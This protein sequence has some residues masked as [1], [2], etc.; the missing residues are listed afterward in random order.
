[1]INIGVFFGGTSVE[2][3]VS[4]ITAQ[5]AISQLLDMKHYK[6]VPIYISKDNNWYTGD[7]LLEIEHF[8][9]LKKVIASSHRCHMVKADKCAHLIHAEMKLFKKTY[10]CDIDLAFPIIHGTGGEDGNLQ[11]FLEHM[12]IPYVG[13]NVLAASLTMDK[14][15]SKLFLQNSGIRVVEG[16]WFYSHHWNQYASS[17]IEDLEKK[18][19]YPLIVKPADIGSSVGVKP[20]KTRSA[21]IEAIDFAKQFS[22]RILIE[23]MLDDMRE[24]NIAVLGDSEK[25]KL[26]VCEEPL[27][28][29]DFLTYE[30]KYVNEAGSKGMSSAKRQIPAKLSD[31]LKNEIECMAAEAFIA[32]D[33]AGVSRIDFMIDRKT[34]LPYINEFNTIPGSLSFYLWEATGVTFKQ[35]LEEMIEAAYRSHRRKSSLIRSNSINILSKADLSGIK[36]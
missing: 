4:I 27:T 7:Y 18:L 17:I 29:S 6:I 20:V 26:S 5:Q 35:M 19:S 8:K 24:I 23:K 34:N 1:M 25:L 13:C 3:E 31:S 28:A 14:I 15:A 16:E 22:T 9:D 10:I 21:L 2:H 36:K 30:D 12:A 33:C 32:L 11:G